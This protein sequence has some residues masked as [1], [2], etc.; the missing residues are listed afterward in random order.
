MVLA[1]QKPDIRCIYKLVARKVEV[2]DK[3]PRKKKLRL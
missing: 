2:S 1:V 3:S